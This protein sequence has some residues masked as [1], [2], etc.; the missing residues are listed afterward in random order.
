MINTGGSEYIDTIRRG[1]FVLSRDLA[2]AAA[3]PLRKRRAARDD[4]IN[5]L[6]F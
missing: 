5:G 3:R 2:A 4:D 6:I 1:F